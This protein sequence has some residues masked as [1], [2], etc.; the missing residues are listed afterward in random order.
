MKGKRNDAFSSSKYPLKDMCVNREIGY[1]S[2]DVPLIHVKGLF[3]LCSVIL[4]QELYPE[5]ESWLSVKI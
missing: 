4:D 3:T 1:P 5:K 2:P